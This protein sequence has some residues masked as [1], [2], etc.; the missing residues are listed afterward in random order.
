MTLDYRRLERAATTPIA[1]SDGIRARGP[2]LREVLRMAQKPL[3]ATGKPSA[4]VG[5][6]FSQAALD[7]VDAIAER[8]GT[9]RSDL[10]RQALAALVAQR[11][12]AA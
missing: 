10:I 5:I 12:T 9:T 6:R 1:V 11:E 7:R 3:D 8:E 2:N 4:F